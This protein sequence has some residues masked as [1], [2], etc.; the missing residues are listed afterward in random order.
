MVTAV[1]FDM[2][3]TLVD[4]TGWSEALRSYTDR[5]DQLAGAWRRH[6]LEISWLVS[7]MERYEDWSAV[8]AYALDVALV[9][10]GVNVTDEERSELLAHARRARLFEGVAG[11]LAGLQ[12]AGFEL[13]VFSNGTRDALGS[14][15]EETGIAGRFVHIVSVD[16]V[17]VFKPA[18]ATYR[19]VADRL[20]REPGQVWLVSG[21][22]FDCAGAK[23]AGLHV[24]KLERQASF[25]YPFADPP[26][27]VVSD[28]RQLFE[29]LP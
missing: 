24:A 5:P 29:R 22:P 7:L 16:E 10:G 12:E 21:N 8:T 20:G 25:D 6:Q 1:A 28:L 4:A 14:I 2:F 18:P 3:G 11:A 19:H 15:L 13:A 27:V 26:D 17:G 9:E 23:A